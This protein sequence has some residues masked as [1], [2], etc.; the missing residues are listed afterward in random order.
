MAN[1]ENYVVY[2]C[3]ESDNRPPFEMVKEEQILHFVSG[4]GRFFTSL[5]PDKTS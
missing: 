3:M 1:G 2:E 5:R 4:D